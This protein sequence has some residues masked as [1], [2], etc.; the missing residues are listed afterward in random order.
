MLSTCHVS[1]RIVAWCKVAVPNDE[2]SVSSLLWVCLYLFFHKL[3]VI[4]LLGVMWGNSYIDTLSFNVVTTTGSVAG[5]WYSVF[6]EFTLNW[7]KLYWYNEDLLDLLR[8]YSIILCGHYNSYRVWVRVGVIFMLFFFVSECLEL[9]ITFFVVDGLV[10]WL[11]ILLACGIF[12]I[13]FFIIDGLVGW[14]S[15]LIV[16]TVIFL[17]TYQ[18]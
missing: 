9:Q 18:S 5:Y 4:C 13:T 8:W 14:L 15:F 2:I 6:Q 16:K 3:I 17:F 11:S 10:V 7:L 12:I 1:S